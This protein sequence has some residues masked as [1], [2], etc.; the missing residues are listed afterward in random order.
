[1]NWFSN[2]KHWVRTKLDSAESNKTA[3]TT[4]SRLPKNAIG[5]PLIIPRDEHQI[6]RKFISDGAL[7][8]IAR[9]RAGGFQGYL[10]GGGVRD[11]LLGK[12]PKDFDVATDARPEQIREL[13]RNSRIIGRRFKIVHVRF[14][15]EIIE[16]TTFR[17]AHAQFAAD[18]EEEDARPDVPGSMRSESGMLLRDN[19]YGTIEEDAIRRDFTVNALYYTTENFAVYDYADGLKDLRA[20]SIRIIGDAA[21]RYREDPVRMLRAIRFAAKLDFSIEPNT[22]EP[23]RR[24]AGLLRD[25]PAARMFDEILKLLMGGHGRATYL[26]LSE[27]GL[28]EVLFPA[29]AEAIDL[30]LPSANELILEALANTD[31]R[32]ADEKPVTPAFIYAALLWPA[33]QQEVSLLATQGLS[34][35]LA[36]QQAIQATID[37][38]QRHTSIPRRFSQPMREIWELQ[39]RLPRRDARRIQNLLDHPRLRAA[40]DFLL[41][42]ERVGESTSEVGQWWTEFLTADDEQRDHLLRKVATPRGS[43]GRPRRTRK[44][45]S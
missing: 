9:L 25:I 20:K 33:L 19:V 34:E 24:L 14:G 5:A 6:S 41:L 43:D 2:A 45:R 18:T 21:T 22:A 15:P 40:Y 30:G 29:S 36:L 38:Q 4:R 42:R 13:F 8:V 28:F 26:L 7:K 16:V 17:G 37:R 27:Y 10:V 32:I 1:L 3:G 35:Q 12:H 31:Q 11:L 39:W 44:P 23:I